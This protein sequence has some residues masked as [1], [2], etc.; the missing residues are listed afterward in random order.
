[1][2]GAKKD[3]QTL[4]ATCVNCL[5]SPARIMETA[6]TKRT[7]FDLASALIKAN[8]AGLGAPPAA[9]ADQLWFKE[10]EIPVGQVWLT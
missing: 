7:M 2:V 10:A 4:L 3:Q 9:K 8:C 1:M 5:P 6:H